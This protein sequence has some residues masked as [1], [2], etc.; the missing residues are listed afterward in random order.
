MK[1]FK[2]F[3]ILCFAIS[4]AVLGVFIVLSFMGWRE[5]LT[6]LTGTVPY[7]VNHAT[8]S[9]KALVYLVSYFGAVLLVPILILTAVI[10]YIWVQLS[11]RNED[12]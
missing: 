7:G 1:W 9:M 2:R 4:T 6:I 11:G 8:A 12:V 10:S 5:N 3:W